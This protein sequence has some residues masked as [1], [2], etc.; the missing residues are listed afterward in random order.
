MDP[1]NINWWIRCNK[2]VTYNGLFRSN[3]LWH[4]S[5]SNYPGQGLQCMTVSVPLTVT[6]ALLCRSKWFSL[7]CFLPQ[8][9]NVFILKSLYCRQCRNC[10]SKSLNSLDL[11]SQVLP[12]LFRSFPF[13]LSC[14]FLLHPQ[15]L[16]FILPKIFASRIYEGSL[17]QRSLLL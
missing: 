7:Y 15:A 10:N 11:A 16:S 5:L 13:S 14:S 2:L 17:M 3:V 9:Q 12:L 1:E 6:L 4:F 8:V